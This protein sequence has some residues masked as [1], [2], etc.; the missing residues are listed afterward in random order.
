MIR[1]KEGMQTVIR[2]LARRALFD[3][4][5]AQAYL[6]RVS[7]ALISAGRSN[8]HCMWGTFMVHKHYLERF[9]QGEKLRP[10]KVVHLE[11]GNHFVGYIS[12]YPY[13]RERLTSV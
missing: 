8:W 2:E 4:E 3:Q 9:K 5:M 1:Y 6:P 10:M 11:R 13:L 7:I 12:L